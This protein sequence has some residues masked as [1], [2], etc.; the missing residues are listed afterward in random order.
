MS[1]KINTPNKNSYAVSNV[2]PYQ[3][4]PDGND[5]E[6]VKRV[7]TQD[8]YSYQQNY[9]NGSD[10]FGNLSA[11]TIPPTFAANQGWLGGV[12]APN[13]TIYT[14]PNVDPSVLAINTYTDVATQ[15]TIPTTIPDRTGY[16]GGVCLPNGKI[17]RISSNVLIQD[18]NTNT[19]SFIRI[20][21]GSLLGGYT[22]CVLAPNGKIYGVPG[23]ADNVIVFNP[24]DDSYSFI[25]SPDVS[26]NGGRKWF[27][28]A[29][30]PNGNIYCFP[31]RNAS[32]IL[33]I[34]T[35]NDTMTASIPTLQGNF[36]VP[37][38]NE[39][40]YWG[41][42][43][44]P[45]GKIYGAPQN[46]SPTD[47]SAGKYFL[48]IDPSSNTYKYVGALQSG[49]RLYTTPTVGMDGWLYCGGDNP[50]SIRF[51]PNTYQIQE[52]GIANRRWGC[53]LAPNGKI[54]FH[55]RQSNAFVSVK[56]GYPQLQPWMMAP[57]FNKF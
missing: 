11:T 24:V 56:T 30:A 17:Y 13:G 31:R 42:C 53:T 6:V 34:N 54:Y 19:F 37:S 2:R 3:F 33:V 36:V 25:T 16:T 10:L 41:G 23:F 43:L 15:I 12:L 7:D 1:L 38:P 49:V 40:V 5:S 57:E 46:N 18:T 14:T 50:N 4:P 48:E 9:F 55:P 52:I 51:N 32:S 26:L 44:A 22:G 20:N 47:A 28:G 39:G 8:V 27:G 21:Y 45:N 29:L 35:N